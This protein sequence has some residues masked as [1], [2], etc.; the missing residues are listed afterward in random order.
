MVN[1]LITRNF[2]VSLF[3]IYKQSPEHYKYIYLYWIGLFTYA[4]IDTRPTTWT[5]QS[6]HASKVFQAFVQIYILDM[7][8]NDRLHSVFIYSSF[9]CAVKICTSEIGTN[10][11]L[12]MG[13]HRGIILN[14]DNASYRYQHRTLT[15][16]SILNCTPLF[17]AEQHW[18]SQMFLNIFYFNTKSV[19]VWLKSKLKIGS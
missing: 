14:A 6:I 4:Y 7:S 1:G 17:G 19:Y 12:L 2:F 15:L 8:Q 16:L 5:C 3:Y 18:D 13:N 11:N 10:Y 9:L